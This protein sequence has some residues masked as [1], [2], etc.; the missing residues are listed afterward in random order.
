MDDIIG[1]I[2]DLTE[3]LEVT[4]NTFFVY[5]SDHGYQLGQLNLN[6]DKRNV[7]VDDYDKVESVVCAVCVC[8]VWRMC[9]KRSTPG[10]EENA[11][12]QRARET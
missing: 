6:W 8:V 2:F 5:T 1:E 12:K 7:Y 10:R 9:V 3:E 4:E 11:Y